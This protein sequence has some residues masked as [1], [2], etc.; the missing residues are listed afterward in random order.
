MGVEGA[1]HYIV[2]EFLEGES[3]AHRLT[4]GPLPPDQ[5]L[6]LGGQIAGALDRRIVRES[7]TATSSRERDADAE[8]AKLVDFGLATL[9]PAL[10]SRGQ[11]AREITQA[12]PLTAE[13]TIVGTFQY[14]APEQLEGTEPDARTDIFALGAV[15]LRDDHRAA[16]LRRAHRR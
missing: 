9:R 8:G 7:S 5:V 1:T 10:H 2:M 15:A 6:K 12:A 11:L 16:R 14:M 13:G 3:L 4:K